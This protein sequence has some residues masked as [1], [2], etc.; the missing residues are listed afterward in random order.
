MLLPREDQRSPL[1]AKGPLFG[2]VPHTRVLVNATFTENDTLKLNQGIVIEFDEVRTDDP[3]FWD[4]RWEGFGIVDGEEWTVRYTSA[5]MNTENGQWAFEVFFQRM[6]PYAFATYDAVVALPNLTTLISL[7]LR[8][9][10]PF[11]AW[12]GV[13]VRESVPEWSPV[14]DRWP[15][16][17]GLPRPT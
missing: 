7:P 8:S 13:C 9:S 4:Y 16:A 14:A 3:P 12:S 17:V 10:S 1:F 11:G 6:D 2:P 15:N 5:G